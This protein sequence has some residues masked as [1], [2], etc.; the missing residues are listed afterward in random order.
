M[1]FCQHKCSKLSQRALE[2]EAVPTHNEHMRARQIHTPGL[3]TVASVLLATSIA[4]RAQETFQPGVTFPMIGI[5]SGETARL[6]AVSLGTNSSTP[7]SSCTVTFAFLD[8]QGQVLATRAVGLAP[9]QA[10]FLDIGKSQ[11]PGDDVR[12][13]IRAVLFFGYSGGAPPTADILQQFDCGIVP[14]LEVYDSNTGRTS[15]VLTGAQ[16]LPGPPTPIP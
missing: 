9:K 3:L 16:P 4:T 12:G 11:V 15:F 1:V 8:A 10:A 6:N 2:G 7:D 14:S 5:A 13:E